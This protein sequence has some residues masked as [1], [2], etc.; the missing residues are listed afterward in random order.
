[1]NPDLPANLPSL[2]RRDFIKTTST[3]LGATLLGGLSIERIAHAANDDT[4]KIALIGCGGRGSGA[5]NQALNTGHAKLVAVADVSQSQIDKSLE[6]LKKEHPDKVDVP[7]ERQFLGVN[8]YKQ[9]IAACDVAF[10]TSPPGFRPSHFDEAV[11]QG[12]NAFLEKPLATDAPGVRQLLAANVD[13]KKKGLRVAVG[14]QRHHQPNYYESIKRIQDGA[15]GD[16]TALR[17]FWRGGSRGGLERLPGETE[18]AYQLRNWYFYTWLSGDHIVEQHC[19][20]IDV[21]NWIKGTHPIRAIG[22]GGR[23]VRTTKE[24]GQIFDH[25]SVQ[26]EYADG[27]FMFS[28]CSQIPHL[29][30]TVSEHVLG[31]KGRA[32]LTDAHADITGANP[33]KY[34]GK[35]VVGW[36]QEQIDLIDCIRNNKACN[37]LEK[38]AYS[39]MTAIMGRMA[40]YSG[41]QIEWDNAFNSKLELV[42]KNISDDMTPPVLP[43]ADGFYP[44]AKP[45]ITIAL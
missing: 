36:Q 27:T 7:K 6:S 13:A 39:T 16:I 23:Q 21:G 25:H 44:V 35:K 5:A 20:N 33:W 19:H 15:I 38:S 30:T 2:H 37:E 40:T 9:A 11:R 34:T 3:A 18:L 43:D 1:M 29:W 10:L 41:Q 17:V 31:T 8:A 24:H 4:I 45:G 22:L 32:D 28:E 42:P 14:F 12:K 26:F